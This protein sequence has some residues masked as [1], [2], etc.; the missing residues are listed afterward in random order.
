[1]DDINF[2]K[3]YQQ[4]LHDISHPMAVIARQWNPSMCPRRKESLADFEPCF[5]G[6][7]HRATSLD[8][9]P[10][11]GQKLDWENI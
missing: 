9:C 11:C 10:F 6:Y 8:R 3:G 2:A 1:M 4:A 7:Y 5:D